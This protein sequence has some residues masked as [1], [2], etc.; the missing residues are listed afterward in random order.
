MNLPANTE[1]H[2]LAH[3][4]HWNLLVGVALS[5]LLLITGLMLSS[6]R[7]RQIPQGPPP[8]LRHVIGEAIRGNGVAFMRLGLIVLMLTPVV[9]VVVL[10]LGWALA[11]DY[12]F[13]LVALMVLGLLSLGVLLSLG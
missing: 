9:R 12:R 1:S 8:P 3:W 11:R 5:G 13:A 10:M 4:V 2:R 6:A 7:G